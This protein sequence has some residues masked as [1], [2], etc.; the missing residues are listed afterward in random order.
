MMLLECKL[1]LEILITYLQYARTVVKLYFVRA[2]P[3]IAWCPIQEIMLRT[4]YKGVRVEEGTADKWVS[5]SAPQWILCM[6]TVRALRYITKS[7]NCKMGNL[8]IRLNHLKNTKYVA[9]K[10]NVFIHRLKQ[11]EVPFFN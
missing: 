5:Y 11:R 1:L 7:C 2:V 3:P 9:S 8:N 6:I 4:Q 10:F